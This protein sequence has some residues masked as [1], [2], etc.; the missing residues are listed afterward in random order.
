MREAP[1][2]LTAAAR[3]PAAARFPEGEQ[4]AQWECSR[5]EEIRARLATERW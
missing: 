5:T 1:A 2:V 4:G 3:L